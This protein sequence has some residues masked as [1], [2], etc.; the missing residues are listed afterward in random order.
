MALAEARRPCPPKRDTNGGLSDANGGPSDA[1]GGL[2]D[3]L[4]V[5]SAGASASVI[6]GGVACVNGSGP[7]RGAKREWL[8][9]KRPCG[10]V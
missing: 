9:G 5:L 8:R 10:D 6:V 3:A 4:R 1:N 2:S 7:F